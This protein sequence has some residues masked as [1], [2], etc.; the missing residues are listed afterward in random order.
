MLSNRRMTGTPH[1]EQRDRNS[2]G[3][4]RHLG[5]MNKPATPEVAGPTGRWRALAVRC[6]NL[7]ETLSS[8]LRNALFVLFLGGI[9]AYGAGFA[10]T[11]STASI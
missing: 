2:A 10:G 11:C 3:D 7:E 4:R 9:L 5:D 6:L 8:R 1:G